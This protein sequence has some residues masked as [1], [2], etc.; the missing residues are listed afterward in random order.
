[1]H[2][3]HQELR[4]Q[5]DIAPLHLLTKDRHRR[6]YS[7][8]LRERVDDAGATSDE[9]RDALLRF[10]RIALVR[11]WFMRIEKE[12]SDQV[13]SHQL[14]QGRAGRNARKDHGSLSRREAPSTRSAKGKRKSMPFEGAAAA[15]LRQARS[16][17]RRF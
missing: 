7:T 5:V 17:G 2:S 6:C 13:I 3:E 14:A 9:E 10:R 11:Y 12:V 8:F 15:A 4:R 1:M 16:G